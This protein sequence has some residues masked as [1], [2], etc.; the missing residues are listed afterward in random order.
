M[1][2]PLITTPE[3]ATRLAR[4]CIVLMSAIL[5]NTSRLKVGSGVL[6]I[7]NRNPAVIAGNSISVRNSL[8]SR[9]SDDACWA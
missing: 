7:Y 6:P 8:R 9:A 4:D 2:P 1:P 3:A 5:A